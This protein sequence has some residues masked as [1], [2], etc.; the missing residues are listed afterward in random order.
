MCLWANIPLIGVCPKNMNGNSTL[1]TEV[2][3]KLRAVKFCRGVYSDVFPVLDSLFP[4]KPDDG[5]QGTQRAKTGGHRREVELLTQGTKRWFLLAW[6]GCIAVYAAFHALHLRADFPN[7]TPWFSD[8]AKYTDE[9]WYGNAAIRAHLFGNWYKPNGLNTAVALPVLPFLEW[10]LFFF[11]GVTVEAAR[12]LTVFFFF[13][14]VALS[15]TLLR[16]RAPR[17]AAMLAVTLLVTSPFCYCFSRLA[18]LEQPL[19]LF[20]LAAL[21]LIVRLPRFRRPLLGAALAGLL[22][23]VMMLTKTTAVFLLPALVWA[24]WAALWQRWRLALACSAAAAATAAVVYGSW[25]ALITHAGLRADFHYLFY[26]NDYP[27][28]QEIYWPLVSLF[29]SAHGGLWVGRVLFSLAA[30]LSLCALVAWKRRWARALL[31][32][33]VFGASMLAVVGYIGFMAY[34]NH[35]QPRYFVV[36]AVFSFILLTRGAAALLEPNAAPHPLRY[37]SGIFLTS[38][39]VA[40]AING[41]VRTAHFVRTPSYTFARAADGLTRYIDTHPNGRR[42]LLTISDDEITLMTHLPGICDDFGTPELPKRTVLDQPGWYAAWNDLDPGTLEDLHT[43]FSLEQVAEFPAF[44]DPER[45]MLVL[46]K[47]HPLANGEVREYGDG[48]LQ[49][50]MPEDRINVPIE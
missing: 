7:F 31:L 19:T 18:I 29:W 30:L 21:N 17:W 5:L 6:W 36:V 38:S 2:T 35:P 50:P 49:H 24:A 23:A 8:W 26:I 34:Q 10:V 37:W 33:P 32:D 3:S 16:A 15:Y 20:F 1:C 28:P 39:L 12:G 47:L 48:D 11:T 25:L 27:K 45:N 40:V 14:N 43:H 22:F 46:F 13:V 41:A 42:L 9:G 44:D 4:R